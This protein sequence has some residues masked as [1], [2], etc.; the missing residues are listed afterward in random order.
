M[1]AVARRRA[2]PGRTGA[3]DRSKSRRPK[4][5]AGFFVLVRSPPTAALEVAGRGPV[6]GPLA[7]ECSHCC[8]ERS[9]VG[10]E[11]ESCAVGEEG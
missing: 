11:C 5:P 7:V 2:A 3:N 4:A 8:C 1:R 10:A 9:T 6:D